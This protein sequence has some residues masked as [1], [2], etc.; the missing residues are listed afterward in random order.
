MN[1]LGDYRG[2][3]SDK[4][5]VELID[6]QS[7]R[8][9]VFKTIKGMTLKEVLMLDAYFEIAVV[10]EEEGLFTSI[11]DCEEGFN[12]EKAEK[13]EKKYRKLIR[14]LR[15]YDMYDH[16]F[17]GTAGIEIVFENKEGLVYRI[18]DGYIESLNG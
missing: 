9:K 2:K 11:E 5:T 15:S 17:T 14:Y 4:V 10:A 16:Y 1:S 18:S 6:V 3:T 7:N 8:D 13:L 12:C